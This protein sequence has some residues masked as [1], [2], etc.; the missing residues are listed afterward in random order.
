MNFEYN[1]IT[2][3]ILLTIA[4]KLRISELSSSVMFVVLFLS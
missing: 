1:M 2:N 3:S 4:K